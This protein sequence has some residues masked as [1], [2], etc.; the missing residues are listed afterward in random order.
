MNQNRIIH[1]SGP[2]M[3][4]NDELVFNTPQ[5]I[6]LKPQGLWYECYNW[7]ENRS[8]WKN[9]DMFQSSS[10]DEDDYLKYKKF[11][12]KYDRDYEVIL[13]YSNIL[14]IDTYDKL[15][16][17][18]SKYLDNIYKLIDW[19]FIAYRFDGI[20]CCNNYYDIRSK[21]N[22]SDSRFTWFHALDIPSGCIWN[23]DAIVSCSLIEKRDREG[24]KIYDPIIEETK[25]DL[26]SYWET[27][28]YEQ[29]KFIYNDADYELYGD[30]LS[31]SPY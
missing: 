6:S 11:Y 12:K 27:H 2:H 24:N 1:H 26:D 25:D 28:K 7:R 8:Y 13:D 4:E 15:L 10:Y 21:I 3:R 31:F 18:T 29:D 17:F 20:E 16:D 23:E 19:N 9:H 5:T 30:E 22:P 14:V